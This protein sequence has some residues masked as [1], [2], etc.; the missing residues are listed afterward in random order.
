M[1]WSTCGTLSYGKSLLNNDFQAANRQDNGPAGIIY[2]YIVP[3]GAVLLIFDVLGTIG[4]PKAGPGAAAIAAN[5]FRIPYPFN[6]E[7][8][9]DHALDM[10]LVIMPQTVVPEQRRLAVCRT[11]GRLQVDEQPSRFR[12][13][14]AASRP[15]STSFMM[16]VICSSPRRIDY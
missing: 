6:P 8:R 13:F 3:A 16:P 12:D 10:V 14:S 5:Y 4:E 1:T 2:S 7:T 9:I 15:A 11:F